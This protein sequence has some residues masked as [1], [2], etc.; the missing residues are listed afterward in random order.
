MCRYWCSEFGP[1]ARSTE[2][3]CTESSF[4]N[5]RAANTHEADDK[6]FSFIYKLSFLKRE[7]ADIKTFFLSYKRYC[8]NSFLRNFLLDESSYHMGKKR[9][10]SFFNPIHSH[11][12]TQTED[13]LYLLRMHKSSACGKSNER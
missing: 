4:F 9:S 8:C 12:K 1:Q 13:T 2:G 6:T 3:A 10:L 5:V 11:Q 7:T